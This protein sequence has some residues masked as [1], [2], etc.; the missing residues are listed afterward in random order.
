MTK[1]FKMFWLNLLK[2]DKQ[3]ILVHS[4]K[5]LTQHQVKANKEKSQW[6]FKIKKFNMITREGLIDL[7]IIVNPKTIDK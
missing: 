4:M 2:M 1:L 6:R 7:R 3:V 5:L